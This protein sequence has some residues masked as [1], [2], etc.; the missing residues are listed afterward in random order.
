MAHDA[1]SQHAHID[2]VSGIE[3]TGH[4]WD[5]VRE[6]NNPLPRWWLW[7]FYATIVWSVG[8]WIAYPAWPLVS[9]YTRGVLGY[10]TRAD[11]AVELDALR[12][13][14]EARGAGLA[15][16]SLDEIR[17]NPALREFAIAQGR[18]AFGDNCAPCHGSG[19]AGGPGYPNLNDDDWIWGGR[20]EDIRQTVR[21]GIRQA[22][23]NDTRLSV[24]PA[25]GR[26][27][28]LNRQQIADVAAF[29]L[30]LSGRAGEGGDV[31][32]GQAV[33]AESCASC[34]GD[35]GRGNQ[36]LG[37]PNLADGIWLYGGTRQAIV[38]TIAN[39]RSGVMPSFIGRLD[40]VTI[41]AL[42][43]YVHSLGGGR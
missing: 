30:T 40:P 5:G 33:Y 31:Q 1:K 41:N 26:D 11:V 24:M 28:L 36:E 14:R 8:Y 35:A 12:A 20:L 39:S 29:V 10:S 7:V 4:E 27:G 6:L 16:A 37:A 9:G 34:H 32:R 13:Q 18:A 19:A 3:T 21:H 17:T 38:E 2:S 43:I 22:G 23:D 25:F 42:T 15:T